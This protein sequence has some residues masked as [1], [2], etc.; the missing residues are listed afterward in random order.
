MVRTSVYKKA[1]AST[2]IGTYAYV[3][4][5]VHTASL[6]GCQWFRYHCTEF[7]MVAVTCATGSAS[8]PVS[9]THTASRAHGDD[10][11]LMMIP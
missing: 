10:R 3:T 5:Q 9:Q 4:V 1:S 2:E 6:A 11:I 7:Q 8:L